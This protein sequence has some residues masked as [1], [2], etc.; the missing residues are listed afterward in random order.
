MSTLPRTNDSTHLS[1]LQQE[2]PPLDISSTSTTADTCFLF[3]AEGGVVGAVF[4][5][6]AAGSGWVLDCA[7]LTNGCHHVLQGVPANNAS[8]IV[9]IS[10]R[11]Y[12]GILFWEQT[13]CK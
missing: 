6:S 9:M 2:N 13:G 7:L 3:L 4:S 1:P 10:R 5:L 12:V 11:M 8:D